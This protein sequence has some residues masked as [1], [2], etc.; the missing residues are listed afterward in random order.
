M[1]AASGFCHDLSLQPV[2]LDAMLV[3]IMS[4]CQRGLIYLTTLHCSPEVTPPLN[5]SE[6]TY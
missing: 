3:L 4:I 5:V 2:M 6:M 1:S